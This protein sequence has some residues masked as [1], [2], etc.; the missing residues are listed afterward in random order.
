MPFPVDEL[1]AV[2]K[3]WDT[4]GNNLITKDELLVIF[5]TLDPTFMGTE[6]EEMLNEAQLCKDG[7]IEV[8][9]FIDWCMGPRPLEAISSEAS[10]FNDLERV[11]YT[12]DVIKKR[13]DELGAQITSDYANIDQPLLFVG[14]LTGAFV[15]H[16]DLARAINLPLE[17]NFISCSSYGAATESSGSVKV[18]KDIQGDVEGRDIIVVDDI[19]DT[20]L[21][22]MTLCESLLSRGARSVR[23]AALLDKKARRKL[24]LDAKLAT[25]MLYRGFE[26]EDAF[27]VGYGMD[28]VEKYRNLPM[29]GV[30]RPCIY[31]PNH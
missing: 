27:V 11:L 17:I 30:L 28:Y 23:V 31:M 19:V 12:T 8:N 24:E 26:C 5:K 13:V 15:F 9:E 14:V 1:K 20:G 3:R 6:L 10:E 18:R 7:K 16:A 4:D 21:T 29:I 2:F 22:M 25:F